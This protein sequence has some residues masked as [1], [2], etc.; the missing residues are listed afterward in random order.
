MMLVWDLETT[1]LP[2]HED[3]PPDRQPRII[4][5][6]AV[7]VSA[8][9][10]V[11]D[12]IGQLIDPEQLITDEIT[13]ITGIKDADLV[14]KPTL[15]QALP[16]LRRAFETASIM[17]THNLPFD[18]G[19]L[20]MDLRRVGALDAWPW[21]ARK[22]CSVQLYRDEWGR[23][24]RLIELYER[25]LGKPYPQTHRALDDA[26]ALAEVVIAEELYTL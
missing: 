25:K 21:P 2:L 5:F 26:R 4:E 15:A 22:F 13:K 18:E 6:G 12:E 3:A 23:N 17:L 16:T 1:G 20:R 24:P 7:L 14:G 10:Q 9:G 8:D 11:V 19:I